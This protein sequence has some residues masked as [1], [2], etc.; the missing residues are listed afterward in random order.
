MKG[1]KTKKGAARFDPPPLG[2]ERA[3]FT[4]SP[5]PQ[6]SP[7]NGRP[8]AGPRPARAARGGKPESPGLPAAFLYLKIAAGLLLLPAVA[9]S[10]AAGLVMNE[11]RAYRARLQ[12]ETWDSMMNDL[13]L[14]HGFL[15][16]MCVVAA[17]GCLLF[18]AVVY[19]AA[20]VSEHLLERGRE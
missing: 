20:A 1:G 13:G 3:T 17:I 2:Q 18:A 11:V 5:G 4:G 8:F 14:P 10:V 6:P 16:A 7:E 15:L 19:T 9:A 12:P